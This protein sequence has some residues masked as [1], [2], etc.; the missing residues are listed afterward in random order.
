MT[1][2]LERPVTRSVIGPLLLIAFGALWLLASQ[3]VIAT[4]NLWTLLRFWPVLLIVLGVDAILRTRWPIVANLFA[5]AA[6]TLAVL[7]VVFAPRLGLLAPTGWMSFIP[8][9][10]GSA[11]GSGNVITETRTVSDFDRVAFSSFGDLTIRPGER[12]GLTIEAEDNVLPEIRTEVRDHTLYIRY[13]DE[14]G[15]PRV[16]PTRPVRLTLTVVDL[17]AV[18]LSGAG[19]VLVDGL[20][21]DAL[22]ASLSGAGGLAVDDLEAE[23]VTFLLS[24]AGGLDASGTTQDLDVVVSGLG[25]FAGGDLRSENAHV[26][27]S[28]VGSATAWA[29]RTLTANLSG[30]GSVDYYGEATVNKHV[31][32]LGTVR[33]LRDK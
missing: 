5:L 26:T 18:D 14:N 27:V 31:S 2:P 25:S 13:T 7:A 16:G 15:W 33:H 8:F 32:G 11:P 22:Q 20:T 17:A 23:A 29:T 6:V 30:L 9:N 4:A 21:T 12:E 10:L 1:Q 19:N 28:G 3:G 24:G